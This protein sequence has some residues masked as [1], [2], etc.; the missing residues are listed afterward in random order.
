M[1]V[2]VDVEDVERPLLDIQRM[3]MSCDA[4]VICA[5][6]AE[7]AARYLE[8]YKA[9]ENKP[10]TA[11]QERVLD[12]YLPQATDLLTTIKIVNKT[13]VLALLSTFGSVAGVCN[14]SMEKLSQCPGFGE[15]K[16][17]K[18]W[19]ALHGQL[20]SSSSSGAKGAS[21]AAAASAAARAEPPSST[22]AVDSGAEVLEIDSEDSDIDS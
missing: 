5:F 18:L 2:L 14:A 12:A 16:L 11:I 6:S 1:L 4:S 10:A 8:T 17:K 21:A 13:D 20:N 9:Y 7:E 22:A 19:E 3:A 15:K